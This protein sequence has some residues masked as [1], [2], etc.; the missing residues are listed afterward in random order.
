MAFYGAILLVVL[1]GASAACLVYVERVQSALQQCAPESR[2]M[3]P[4]LAWLMVVPFL[5]AAWQFRV[6]L[7]VGKSFGQE[8]SGRGLPGYQRGLRGLGLAKSVVDALALVLFVVAVVVAAASPQLF[9][10]SGRHT[11]A[12]GIYVSALLG[13]C[14]LLVPAL[15]LWIAYWGRLGV[16]SRLL[17]RL[18]MEGMRRRAWSQGWWPWWQAGPDLHACP[19]CGRMLPAE[20]FCGWCGEPQ[21]GGAPTGSSARHQ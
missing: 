10:E 16:A 8:F 17:Q 4:G 15:G 11:V 21:A 2:S 7:A 3:R 12:E 14:V 6:A 20:R 1:L 5:G 13:C 19:G 9:D 18:V